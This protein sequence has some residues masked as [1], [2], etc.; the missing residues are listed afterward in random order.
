MSN[1]IA[2]AEG[3]ADVALEVEIKVNRRPVK[4]PSHTTGAAIKDA[5]GVPADDQLFRIQGDT[6][7]LVRSNE[8][9]EVRDGERFA[10]TP[11]LEP[12]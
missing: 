3:A 11:A 1:P 12:A 4:V 8:T 2:Q 5:A 9:I 10:A 6:E 7:V